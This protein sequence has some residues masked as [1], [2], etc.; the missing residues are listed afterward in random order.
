MSKARNDRSTRSC[1][2][3]RHGRI[4]LIRS[5]TGNRKGCWPTKMATDTTTIRPAGFTTAVADMLLASALLN[6]AALA[7]PLLL[8]QIYDRIIPNAAYGTLAALLVGV[9]L[10]IALEAA[11]RQARTTIATWTS[12]REEH[13]LTVAAATRILHADPRHL[14][15]PGPLADGMAAIGEWR[16][17]RNSPSTFALAD[18][19]FVM[20]FL[21]FLAWLSPLLAGAALAA[22]AP[23]LL[24]AALLGRSAAR[25]IA[26]RTE[27]ETFRHALAQDAVAA[28][29]PLKAMSAEAQMLR[30]HERLVAASAAAGR[31]TIIRVQLCQAL[32]SAGAQMVVAAVALTGAWLMMQ[33]AISGGAAAAAILLASRGIE[34]LARLAAAT[35]TL[36][37]A[38]AARRRVDTVLD[39]P[40]ERQDGADPGEVRSLTL[41][42]VA[43]ATPGGEWLLQGVSFDVRRGECIA[44]QGPGGGGKTRLILALAGLL[45]P[46]G[47]QVTV[48]G[49]PRDAL[50]P[51]ALR[52]QTALLPQHPSL[53]PGRVI[54][55]LTGFDPESEATALALATELG[56]DSH[57]GRLP[58]G[59]A[60]AIG[61]GGA[62]DLPPSVTERVAAVRALAGGRR[63]ILFDDAARTQDQDGDRR[64]RALIAR[65][66]PDAITVLVSDRAEWLALADR[67]YRIDAGRLIEVAQP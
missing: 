40:Q 29:E 21:G 66:K 20:V 56:L 19:P 26:G 28:I 27:A 54:D 61:R 45:P 50:D 33:Q 48:N 57:F 35:P 4:R 37:R 58:D 44:I 5:A 32:A 13:A 3:G 55:N 52:R 6:L 23:G 62:L 60:T 49:L 36:Q 25:A 53:V 1:P 12:A 41:Q 30:R 51:T 65:L 7:L 22:A 42:D 39:V 11:L 14:P 15:T 16:S 63:L 47:G 67:H 46:D 64:M 24:A 38:R 17:H 31:R 59:Y 8:L 34:P 18:L 9:G 10:A 43:F 2:G